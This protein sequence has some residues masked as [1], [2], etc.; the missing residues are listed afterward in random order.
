MRIFEGLYSLNL[1]KFFMLWT[2]DEGAVALLWRTDEGVVDGFQRLPLF[3]LRL[4]LKVE[5]PCTRAFPLLSRTG[6]EVDD[7]WGKSHANNQTRA[8][9]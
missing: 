3:A 5:E 2:P 4:F 8:G 6:E 7:K 1:A 9:L